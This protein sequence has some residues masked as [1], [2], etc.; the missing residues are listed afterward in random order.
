MLSSIDFKINM[1]LKAELL[2]LKW[3]CG[4][5]WGLEPGLVKSI[6]PSLHLPRKTPKKSLKYL[7]SDENN[8]SIPPYFPVSF[9]L[10]YSL[11]TRF[12]VRNIN[13]SNMERKYNSF[14]LKSSFIFLRLVLSF[15]I[16]MVTQN[17]IPDLVEN[18][19]TFKILSKQSS[20]DG[21][22]KRKW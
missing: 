1:W 15:I 22:L 3:G 16:K 5:S 19:Q 7:W 17:S 21:L 18:S 6:S 2:W 9:P 11:R 13:F 20:W 8:Y 4:Q 10:I 14:P 12:V